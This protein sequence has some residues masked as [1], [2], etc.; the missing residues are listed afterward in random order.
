MVYEFHMKLAFCPKRGKPTVWISLCSLQP[1]VA[2]LLQVPE[3]SSVRGLSSHPGWAQAWIPH[4]SQWQQPPHCRNPLPLPA[5]TA[6]LTATFP[7]PISSSLLREPSGPPMQDSQAFH[8]SHWHV[9]AV[10]VGVSS[11][12][13]QPCWLTGPRMAPD[14]SQG[15]V[16][17]CICTAYLWQLCISPGSREGKLFVWSN[18]GEGGN[19]EKDPEVR[20]EEKP[21]GESVFHLHS[22]GGQKEMFVP[23]LF[24]DVPNW[25]KWKCC[26]K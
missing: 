4:W 17:R 14:E 1:A 25:E 2:A 11:A 20:D 26:K 15:W 3:F 9:L 18:H 12:A 13:E 10:A 22:P 5:T 19:A 23:S 6:K 16:T 24:H 21:T 7:P 8:R